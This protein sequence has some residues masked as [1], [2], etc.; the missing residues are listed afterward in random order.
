[1]VRAP[2]F[3][4]QSGLTLVEVSI[5]SVLLAFIGY[6]L[7]TSMDIGL[8]S[9]ETVSESINSMEVLRKTARGL[10]DSLRTASDTSV[11]VT[12]LTS[13]DSQLTIQEPLTVSGA[14]NWGVYDTRL[15]PTEEEH[16]RVGWSV[17]YTVVSVPD[18]SNP[19]TGTRS[20]LRYRILDTGDSVRFEETIAEGL[21]QGGTSDPGFQVQKVGDL[22]EV[23]L[24][25]TGAFNNTKG[26]TTSMHVRA[27]N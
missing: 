10:R 18:T 1:M 16:T 8:R 23:T 9:H 19:A 12:T 26:P 2:K 27:R 6:I 20:D 17:R 7:T 4:K 5:S 22:W 3:N 14:L 24:Q 13:G 25:S 11:T 15:G 21:F